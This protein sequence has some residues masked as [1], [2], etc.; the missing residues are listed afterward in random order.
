MN[1]HA[2]LKGRSTRGAVL[3]EFTVALVPLLTIFFCFVQVAKLYTASLVVKHGAVAAARAAIVIKAPNPGN[4]GSEGDIGYAAGIA[5]GD[6]LKNGSLTSPSVTTTTQ[7][8]EAD[9]YG[10]VTSTVSV[11]YQCN[12]PLGGLIVCLGPTKTLTARMSLPNQGANYKE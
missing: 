8:S 7:A 2:N 3:V 5:M 6:W 10:L 9:P 4:N 12:V 11:S 1:A